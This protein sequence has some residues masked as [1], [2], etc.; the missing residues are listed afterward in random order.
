[1]DEKT[2]ETL[3]NF[4]STVEENP[5]ILNHPEMHFYREHLHRMRAMPGL[6]KSVSTEDRETRKT[7]KRR[8][9]PHCGHCH[10]H[11]IEV[12]SKGHKRKCPYR[13][14]CSCNLCNIYRKQRQVMALQ[15]QN[16]RIQVS[17]ESEASSPSPVT[18][19]PAMQF[20]F[21]PTGQHTMGL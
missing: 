15:I 9:S 19:T 13:N 6:Q 12:P 16:R 1:M 17:E 18:S 11:G 8:K 21:N 20:Q 14:S 4:C 5:Q 3:R 2:L 7:A 10:I